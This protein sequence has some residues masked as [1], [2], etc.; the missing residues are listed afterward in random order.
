MRSGLHEKFRRFD[1][2]GPRYGHQRR[3]TFRIGRVRIGARLEQ[4]TDDVGIACFGRYRHGGSAIVVG[5]RNVRTGADQ[6]FD[7]FGVS[8]V[9]GPLQ[10][11][12]GVREAYI[13]WPAGGNRMEHVV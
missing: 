4:Q 2:A 6:S 8:P 9:G 13:D 1:V 3:L 5:S 10:G 7:L 12:A 11:G